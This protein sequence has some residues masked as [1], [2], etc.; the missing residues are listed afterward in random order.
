MS[1][2]RLPRARR[3]APVQKVSTTGGA[4]VSL[5]SGENTASIYSAFFFDKEGEPNRVIISNGGFLT[6]DQVLALRR[7]W[8]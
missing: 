5:P 1:R 6:D 4:V 7:A 3:A 2:S 8:A